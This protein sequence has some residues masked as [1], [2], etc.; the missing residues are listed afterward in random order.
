LPCHPISCRKILDVDGQGLAGTGG[1]LVQQPPQR[2]LAHADV[3]AA[4]QPFQLSQGNGLGAVGRSG[5]RSRSNGVV[6]A[7]YAFWPVAFGSVPGWLAYQVY[8]GVKHVVR[9]IGRLRPRDK[10]TPLQPPKP[11]DQR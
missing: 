5:R 6:V 3:V 11:F 2:L 1:R 9:I 4:P 8:Q 10:R 7:G